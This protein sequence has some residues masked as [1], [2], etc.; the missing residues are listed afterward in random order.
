VT[1]VASTGSVDSTRDSST[2]GRLAPPAPTTPAS[3][4]ATDRSIAVVPGGKIRIRAEP[5][6][7][8][9][10]WVDDRLLGTGVV[11]DSVLPVGTRKLKIVAP[12]FDTHE[13]TFEIVSGETNNLGT[14]P[15]RPRGEKR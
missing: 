7:A 9:E 5:L 14:I 12:G 10:I 15:L 2:A 13:A 4:P 11:I 6:N 8:A 1:K 3:R